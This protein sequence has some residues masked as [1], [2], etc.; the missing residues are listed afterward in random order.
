[1]AE[2]VSVFAIV[3][4]AT[5]IYKTA[6]TNAETQALVQKL[7]K[8]EGK[9]SQMDKRTD[10]SKKIRDELVKVKTLIEQN[11]AGAAGRV[12]DGALAVI[13]M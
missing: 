8:L 3:G 5:W 10:K 2:P 11:N 4:L 13:G 6:G 9:Y 12:V 7:Q 1:M